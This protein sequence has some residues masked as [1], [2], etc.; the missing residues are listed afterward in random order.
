MLLI[1]NVTVQYLGLPFAG[2]LAAVVTIAWIALTRPQAEQSSYFQP[3]RLLQVKGEF[4]SGSIKAVRF[5]FTNASYRSA[6][7]SVNSVAI[8]RRAIGAKSA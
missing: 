4:F 1:F 7:E 8:E 6:F 2:V 3:V 5:A